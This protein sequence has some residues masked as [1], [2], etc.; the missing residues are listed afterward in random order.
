MKRYFSL[1][2]WNLA[3]W[4]RDHSGTN[5]IC[6]S[7]KEAI[8]FKPELLCLEERVTPTTYTVTSFGNSG[9]GTLRD[10]ITQANGTKADDSIV[11]AIG[12][13]VRTIN[14]T[15]TLPSIVSTATAGRLRIEGPGSDNLTLN[16]NTGSSSRDFRIFNIA[17]R[18]DL[19]LRGVTLSGAR[20]STGSGA[21]LYNRDGT[22]EV[23]NC[24]LTNN[25]A[26]D[27]GGAIR[28][29]TGTLTV[30]NSTI[31]NNKA[32]NG[33]G[34]SNHF[35]GKVIVQNSTLSGN[36]AVTDG[37]GI[38]N[39]G[40]GPLSSYVEV[41]SSTLDANFAGRRG[42]ALFNRFGTVN[43][44]SSSTLST[45]SA[46]A[47]GGAISTD[48]GTTRVFGNS[49]LRDNQAGD[50]GGAI[51]NTGNGTLEVTQS[52]LSGNSVTNNN[53]VGGGI[54]NTLEGRIFL[55]NATISG[56]FIVDNLGD[57]GGIHNTGTGLLSITSDSKIS[58]NKAR[59]GGGIFNESTGP[60][61][62]NDSTI[63]SNTA[64][65]TEKGGGGIYNSGTLTLDHCEVSNNKAVGNEGGGIYNRGK[66]TINYCLVSINTT[67]STQEN[68]YCRGGGIVNYGYLDVNFSTVSHNISDGDAGGIYIVKASTP[69]NVPEYYTNIYRSTISNNTAND[70][71]GGI[72]ADG[73][74]TVY[75]STIKNN[76]ANGDNVHLNFIDSYFKEIGNGGGIF[77]DKSGTLLLSNSTVS[78]NEAGN[79]GGGIFAFTFGT[80]PGPQNLIN[81]F[82]L[83]ARPTAPFSIINS[84]VAENRT[85]NNG[86]GIYTTSNSEIINCTIASNQASSGSGIDASYGGGLT[87][88]PNSF[89]WIIHPSLTLQNTII[90]NNPGGD[91]HGYP[92]ALA[93]N[94]MNNLQTDG[95]LP[96]DTSPN[97]DFGAIVGKPKLGPLQDNG[98]P[99]FTMAIFKD[100][101]AYGTGGYLISDDSPINGLDQR[102]YTRVNKPITPSRAGSDIGAFAAGGIAPPAL[103]VSSPESSSSRINEGYSG[104]LVT[105]NWVTPFPGFRGEIHLA[106]G[107]YN[108][109][110]NGDGVADIVAGAGAGGGP[111][112]AIVDSLTRKV[113]RAFY[114]F[115]QDF[116]GGVNVSTLD[117]N[118]DGVMDI[119]AAAG[120]GGG[121]HVKIFNGVD[122]SVLCS[123]Y[124]YSENFRGGVSICAVDFNRDG[125][126]DLVTGAGPGGGPHVRVFDG[127]TRQIL[128]QWYAYDQGFGG[129]VF[130][131]GGDLDQDGTS[132]VITG[133][134]A[135]GGPEI[136]VWNP[137]TR[138]VFCRLL[139]YDQEFTGGVR[140]GVSDGNGDGIQE[141][142]T[143]PGRGGIPQ[144][145]GFRL[146]PPGSGYLHS[147]LDLVFEFLASS[148]TNSQGIFVS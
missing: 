116:A 75:E 66:V 128:S 26:G 86:G 12:D 40:D 45:N 108:G 95:S 88:V 137:F 101:A 11:F 67:I 27:F 69:P 99:T 64:N 100:S 96:I 127:S 48:S 90:A 55:T 29:D 146:T 85:K 4:F 110:F 140:L 23:R 34:I 31:S 24:V 124:A 109:D 112:I 50:F 7:K 144:V 142:I 136:I 147:T 113:L 129:G 115:S 117:Y 132:E 22:V 6:R 79:N 94:F 2:K 44:S 53:G 46:T 16:G 60:L 37:G 36:T 139:A 87:R 122:L 14:L 51:F 84:T 9:A 28:N 82:I 47:R 120:P 130:V 91:Y 141:L 77:I 106:N 13:S 148:R 68:Q 72:Y 123:F 73:D 119:V 39:Y 71:G 105:G 30:S 8:P 83:L 102:G 65:G 56:N 49:T 33:G 107:D 121:P 43:I 98:G 80:I 19:S 81:A 126:R 74:I 3:T 17:S 25:T 35:D 70:N 61:T 62:I 58:D 93:G 21:A 52:T 57:G 103:Y 125:V 15:S 134:G 18:G 138:A 97:Y 38:F 131:S 41:I 111:A 20:T 5:P 89:P 133:P 118:I 54:S 59:L 135:G 1:A 63:F 78:G 76:I 10:A 104:A 143:G 32:E 145:K 42:G 114:A 92:L